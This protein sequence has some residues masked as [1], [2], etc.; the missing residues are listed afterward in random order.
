MMAYMK[1]AQKADLES[2]GKDRLPECPTAVGRDEPA[3]G[4]S[5]RVDCDDRSLH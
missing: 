2:K 4:V 5:V 3:V 1:T